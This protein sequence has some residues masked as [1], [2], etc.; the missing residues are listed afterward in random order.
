MNEGQEYIVGSFPVRSVG[1]TTGDCPY[2]HFLSVC[3]G[4][5]HTH[6]AKG[7][8]VYNRLTFRESAVNMTV[9]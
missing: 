5:P 6:Q 1:A 8:T 2:T 4:K 3:K 7:L 9:K